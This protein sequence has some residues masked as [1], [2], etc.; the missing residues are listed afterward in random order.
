MCILKGK[1][2][3]LFLQAAVTEHHRLSGLQT[4][5]TP[6]S[7]GGW[8][9]Q[10][11]GTGRFG[12]WW[13]PLP[14]SELLSFASS[15]GGGAER[16]LWGPFYKG[17]N[18]FMRAPLWQPNDLPKAPPP[19]TITLGI[20][21]QHTNLRRRHTHSVYNTQKLETVTLSAPVRE[22]LGRWQPFQHSPHVTSK[23]CIQQREQMGNH[24]SVLWA[25]SRQEAK[26]KVGFMLHA[27][28]NRHSG[29][30]TTE[31]HPYFKHAAMSFRGPILSYL[32]I[33]EL[34]RDT[35]MW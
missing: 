22:E 15:H 33:P 21:F 27:Q 25:H 28:C 31:S 16:A 7:P 8:E 3:V 24:I 5:F 13:G 11:Q 29:M 14:G 17:T 30:V 32:C 20:R 2:I 18:P 9:V 26:Y 1:L 10:V 34:S 35:C 6:H 4:T 19:N 23:A 12:A